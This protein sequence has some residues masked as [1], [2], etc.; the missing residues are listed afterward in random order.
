MPR[1]SFSTSLEY[2]PGFSYTDVIYAERT[3]SDSSVLDCHLID[4]RNGLP[5]SCF[6]DLQD[7]MLYKDARGW[8]T[9]QKG[10][11]HRFLLAIMLS[12][13][14]LVLLLALL[15][16]VEAVR[17]LGRVNPATRELTWP[18]TGVSFTFTGSS[19][20]IGIEATTGTN[21]ADLIV[22]GL[23]TVIS[24]VNGT[25]FSTSG[26]RHGNHTVVIRKRSEASYGTITVGNVTT[27][28]DFGPDVYSDRKIEV[29]GD[30][31]TVGYGLDG[32]LPCV[33]SAAV[34]DN[35]KTYAALAADAVGADY[36][37]IAWSGIGV[38][39]NYVSPTPDTSDIMPQRYTRYGA[40]DPLNSYTFPANKTPDAVVIGLGTNDFGYQAGVRDPIV[41]S[42]YT[43][44][45]VNFVRT[46]KSHYPKASFFLLTSPMLND[47]YPST[48]DAQKTTQRNALEAVVAQLKNSTSIQVVDMPS[49]G[50]DVGCDYHPNA[51]TH[52]EEAE[53]LAAALTKEMGW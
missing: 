42:E 41:P 34:E 52:A 8:Q 19:A 50:S 35:P 24:D 40:L 38:T 48:A 5:V 23:T 45:M 21:S 10:V 12:K 30:S 37:I 6:A 31:I 22:D 14:P 17:F 36:D 16:D 47:G 33:N 44:A 25:S 32:V 7:R 28:G 4:A 51:A 2:C 20:R 43:A 29:I 9:S 1:C 15:N 27:D 3:T 39:R 26:L 11:A 18:G 13:S 53:I 46:I 49:Q